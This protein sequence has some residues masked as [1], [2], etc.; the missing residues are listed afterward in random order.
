MF[1]LMFACASFTIEGQ[2][3]D[4]VEGTCTFEVRFAGGSR[5]YETGLQTITVRPYAAASR[6]CTTQSTVPCDTLRD[7]CTRRIGFREP[8]YEE[9]RERP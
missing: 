6:Y 7:I 3:F 8:V 9:V 2:T 5:S 4:E 1:V